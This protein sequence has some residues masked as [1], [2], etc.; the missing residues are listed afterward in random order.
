MPFFGGICYC[1]LVPWRVS[2]FAKKSDVIPVVFTIVIHP[3][4]LPLTLSVSDRFKSLQGDRSTNHRF[5]MILPSYAWKIKIVKYT[6]W[7]I[8]MEP[9][10]HPFSK[11]NDLPKP[12]WWCS[13]LIFRGVDYNG[14]YP[15]TN[16]CVFSIPDLSMDFVTEMRHLHHRHNPHSPCPCTWFLGETNR[17]DSLNTIM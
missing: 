11:E 1:W 16:H 6:P 12:P 17:K 8:N 10:N 7:K 9:T 4:R 5:W 15:V 3:L 13:M 2:F 14:S